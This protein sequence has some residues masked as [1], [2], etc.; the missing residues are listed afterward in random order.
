MTLRMIYNASVRSAALALLIGATAAPTQTSVVAVLE[1]EGLK[2][3]AIKGGAQLQ[4]ELAEMFFH[5]SGVTQSVAEATL[6]YRR[7]AGK[8]FA[9]AQLSLARIYDS[10]RAELQDRAEAVRW[11]RKA[12]DH[13][14]APAQF[15]LG[16]AYET[17]R[18]VDADPAVATAWYR[19]AALRGHG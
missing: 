12:A 10:G 1:L 2:A 15:A 19:F 13:G 3:K 9:P 7:A 17:G 6:W 8:N 14:L 18:G 4:F 11:Y 5:G 16:F